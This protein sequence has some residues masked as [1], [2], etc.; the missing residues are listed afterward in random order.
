MCSN[1]IMP[2]KHVCCCH[3]LS[4]ALKILLPDLSGFSLS[5]GLGKEFCFLSFVMEIEDFF[6]L[7]KYAAVTSASCPV[8]KTLV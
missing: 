7:F 4:L 3:V 5:F 1:P 2:G 8:R 6:V